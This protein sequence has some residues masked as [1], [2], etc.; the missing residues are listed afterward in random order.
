MTDGYQGVVSKTDLLFAVGDA[1]TEDDLTRFFDVARM[2]LAEDNPAL[3]LE[4]DQRWAA[5][6]YGKD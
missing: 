3:D 5:S 6:M 1:L 4:E 2:V